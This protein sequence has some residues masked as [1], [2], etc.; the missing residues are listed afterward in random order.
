MVLSLWFMTFAFIFSA[1]RG[2]YRLQTRG[3]EKHVCHVAFLT[4]RDI[5]YFCKMLHEWQS[6]YSHESSFPSD[7]YLSVDTSF[8]GAVFTQLEFPNAC[9]KLYSAACTGEFVA[10]LFFSCFRCGKNWSKATVFLFNQCST[11]SLPLNETQ[12]HF[13]QFVCLQTRFKWRI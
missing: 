2:L 10:F 12:V 3:R 8:E 13:L 6:L 4:E 9:W 1:L 7:V 11:S 5:L